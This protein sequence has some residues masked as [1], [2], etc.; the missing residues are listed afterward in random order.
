MACERGCCETQAEHY[1]SL[2]VARSD[3]KS[4]K[5]V[6]TDDHGTHTVDVTEHWTDRQ[7][8]TVKPSTVRARA[9]IQPVEGKG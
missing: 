1:R 5:K 6:T 3:R 9:S 8:V 4:M 2:S 7:D